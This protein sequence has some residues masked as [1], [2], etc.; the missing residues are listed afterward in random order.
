MLSEMFT[1][2]HSFS[3]TRATS[4][5]IDSKSTEACREMWP[6]WRGG[7]HCWVGQLF[8][9]AASLRLCLPGPKQVV[10]FTCSPPVYISQANNLSSFAILTKIFHNMLFI[11]GFFSKYMFICL[12]F[13]KQMMEV[14]KK[15]TVMPYVTDEVWHTRTSLYKKNIKGSCDLPK[16]NKFWIFI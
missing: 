1:G 4:A 7:G 15:R 6:A 11:K 13:L 8:V 16:N 9:K 14:I 3:L 12:F 5:A 10:V 2:V